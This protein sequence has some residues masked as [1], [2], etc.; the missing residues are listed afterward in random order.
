MEFSDKILWRLDEDSEW[1]GLLEGSCITE[2]KYKQ[3][4]YLDKC[5]FSPIQSFERADLIEYKEVD[6]L[7]E[8]G[9]EAVVFYTPNELEKFLLKI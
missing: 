6:Y 5:L 7:S 4:Y 1:L 3:V 8:K 9:I 2:E